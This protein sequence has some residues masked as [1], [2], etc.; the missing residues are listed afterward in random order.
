MDETPNN[1]INF[2]M[3]RQMRFRHSINKAKD[4]LFEPEQVTYKEDDSEP[5][6]RVEGALDAH[7]ED[8]QNTPEYKAIAPRPEHFETGQK[9]ALV[10]NV[11]HINEGREIKR[12]KELDNE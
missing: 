6:E 7:I 1:V 10:D 11:H 4:A 3:T 5:R 8:S 9:E 2:P 12:R